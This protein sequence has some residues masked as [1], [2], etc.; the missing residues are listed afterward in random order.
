M[1]SWIIDPGHGGRERSGG[2]TPFGARAL[3]GWLEKEI[4]LDVARRIRRRAFGRVLLTREEDVN[5]SLGERASISSAHAAESFLSLHVNE[6]TDP[7]AQGAE[8][9]MH[10]DAPA[11][12][13]LLAERLRD[14][15]L[16]AGQNVRGIYR[17]P[18]A[19]LDPARHPEDAAACLV[20]LG[21]ATH[22][23]DSRRLG[24]PEHRDSIASGIAR[25]LAETSELKRGRVSV[26]AR[27]ESFDIW[28]EVPLV[29]QLTGMSCWAAA[30]AMVV[31][32]RD[33]IDVDAEEVAAATGRW[34]SYRDGLEPRDVDTLARTF[35][36]VAEKPRKYTLAEVRRL[37][38]RYGPLWVGEAS[39]GLHVVVIAGMYGDGTPDGT[40]VRI[41]DPWPIGRG[42][43]YTIPFREL[44][45][46]LDAVQTIAGIDAQVM[47]SGGRACGARGRFFSRREAR[48][49]LD[50]EGID[51]ERAY[52]ILIPSVH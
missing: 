46:R 16:A 26:R 24:D 3:D 44:A 27:R 22:P 1:R 38:E 4:A 8:I 50:G 42:E 45:Q 5:R 30:A 40:F 9:W 52:D 43:R 36:L 39:P 33:C 35:G 32:W 48:L 51:P 29:Q 10:S 31:G 11:D 12:C 37:L 7:R 47:H 19:V 21:Y 41:A 6:S 17:G 13:E 20:E 34:E 25:A 49:T 2:S 23:L 18:L 15:I 14:A 28:H